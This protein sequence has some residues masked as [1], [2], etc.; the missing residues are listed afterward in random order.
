MGDERHCSVAR[1]LTALPWTVREGVWNARA[2]SDAEM[3]DD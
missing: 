1:A 3:P 2:D